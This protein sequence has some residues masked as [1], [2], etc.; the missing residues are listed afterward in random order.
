MAPP[1]SKYHLG[2]FKNP[3]AQ[4]VPRPIKSESVEVGPV[5]GT[6]KSGSRIG[7][8]ALIHK[9]HHVSNRCLTGSRRVLR[10]LSSGLCDDPEGWDGDVSGTEGQEGGVYTHTH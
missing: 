3:D 1:R 8:V 10:V 4:D 2:N 5:I 9:H 6:L 7:S